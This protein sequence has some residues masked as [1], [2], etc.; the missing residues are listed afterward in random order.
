MSKAHRIFLRILWLSFFIYLGI[1]YIPKYID[2]HKFFETVELSITETEF[3]NEIVINTWDEAV[4]LNEQGLAIQKTNP[5][6]AE[7]LY[8]QAIEKDP[9][10][11][12]AYNNLGILYSDNGRSQEA[13]DMYQKAIQVKPDYAKAYNNLGVWYYDLGDKKKALELYEI[14]I[15]FSDQ[16]H[17][18]SYGNI[19]LILDLEMGKTNEAIPYYKKA[20]E[21][22]SSNSAV[23]NR[24][25]ELGL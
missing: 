25:K 7:E 2:L 6:L 17:E 1:Q 20:V 13:F 16:T 14:S 24:A 5:K 4:D 11:Y 8:K 12:Y 21:L 18:N 3:K 10:F 9:S 23:I 15:T 19:A 22:G